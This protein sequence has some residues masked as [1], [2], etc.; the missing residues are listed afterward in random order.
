MVVDLE[1]LR[2][3]QKELIDNYRKWSEQDKQSYS[4]RA[5][6][7]KE[8]KSFGKT[9]T[10]ARKL[11][12]KG[13]NELQAELSEMSKSIKPIRGRMPV[14]AGLPLS[15]IIGSLNVRLSPQERITFKQ[16]YENFKFKMATFLIFLLSGVFWVPQLDIFAATALFTFYMLMTLR[17]S[18]LVRN[19]SRIRWWWR[20]HHYISTFSAFV[21]IGWTPS[22]CLIWADVR[23]LVLGFM[24]YVF[25]V[26]ILQTR[27]QLG[28]LY[29][30]TALDRAHVM[31]T[32]NTESLQYR[33]GLS[34]PILIPFLWVAH[35]WQFLIGFRIA[36]EFIA[37]AV[38]SYRSADVAVP[39]WQ[40]AVVGI[41]FSVLGV[42]NAW[43]T[44]HVAVIRLVA[45]VRAK[46]AGDVDE[47]KDKEE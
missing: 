27:Y 3:T 45:K 36:L 40:A 19:G 14:V 2:G 29:T 30:L 20:S 7:E 35:A 8:L 24:I 23:R 25:V 17:E 28:R 22:G 47:K 31:D 41:S 46:K 1:P 16:G 37:Q 34:M 11:L 15:P 18:I 5:T 9:I 26:Q 4:A 21:L 44:L 42:G 6:L 32:T 10:E 43:T 13:D 12:G 33:K 39:H 38:D